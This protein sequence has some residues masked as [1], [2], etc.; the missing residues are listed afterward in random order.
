[1]FSVTNSLQARTRVCSGQCNSKGSAASGRT[2]NTD[3][4]GVLLNNSIRNGEAEASATSHT[5]GRVERIVNLRDVFRGDTDSSISHLDHE[6]TVGLI[7]G[8]LKCD[9]P[10][11]RYCVA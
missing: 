4:A 8:S 5:L 6:G 3:V 10:P 9:T 7:G 2:L 1:M 11:I